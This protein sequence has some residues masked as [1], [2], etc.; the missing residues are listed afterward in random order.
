MRASAIGDRLCAGVS[1]GRKFHGG[2][3]RVTLPSLTA[4]GFLTVLPRLSVDQGAPESLAYT[5][6]H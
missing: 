2:I 5:D 4:V 6:L 3:E 1:D